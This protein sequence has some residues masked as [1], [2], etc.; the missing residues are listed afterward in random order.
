MLCLLLVWFGAMP[1]C[2]DGAV[3]AKRRNLAPRGVIFMAG[4]IAQPEKDWIGSARTNLVAWWIPH[5]VI[6]A[7]LFLP[8]PVR[9]VTWIIAL[10]W[11]GMACFLNARRCGRTHC[12]FTGPYYF[13]MIIPVLVLGLDLTSAGLTSW[14][15]LAV[16]IVLGSKTIWWATERAWGKFSRLHS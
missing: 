16:F 6:L 5:G 2:P 9:T 8:V 11:M 13:I 10:A 12:W 15:V 4:D 7:G 14:V 3:G 1:T